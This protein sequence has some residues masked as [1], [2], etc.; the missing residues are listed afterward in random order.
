M[1]QIKRCAD[2]FTRQATKAQ[3]NHLYA[4]L[5][6]RSRLPLCCM[7][8]SGLRFNCVEFALQKDV[9][10]AT[11]AWAC[12]GEI[13][14]VELFELDVQTMAVWLAALK[15]R[16]CPRRATEIVSRLVLL[17]EKGCRVED[18]VHDSEGVKSIFWIM[19]EISYRCRNDVAR[20]V[21]ME[22]IVR[23]QVQAMD[24]LTSASMRPS[25]TYFLTGHGLPDHLGD[26]PDHE[27]SGWTTALHESVKIASYRMVE[28]LVL[29]EFQVNAFDAKG[30]TAYQYSGARLTQAGHEPRI[31]G[32]ESYEV[33]R[34]AALLSQSTD[35]AW[36]PQV[37]HESQ[38]NVELSLP[39]G[40]DR[41]NST[42]EQGNRKIRTSVTSKVPST[43]TL[44]LDRH[45][46]SITLKSPTFSFFTDQRLALGFRKVHL[47]G[48][49]YY[50]DLLRFLQPPSSLSSRSR[51]SEPTYSL[52]Y[53]EREA[54]DSDT[55]RTLNVKQSV[56][57]LYFRLQLVLAVAYAAI[58]SVAWSIRSVVLAVRRALTYLARCF[59]LVTER[60]IRYL[61][62]PLSIL[63]IFVLALVVPGQPINIYLGSVPAAFVARRF[64]WSFGMKLLVNLVAL[65]SL[66]N[67]G[68]TALVVFVGLDRSDPIFVDMVKMFINF[69]VVPFGNIHVEISVSKPS[70]F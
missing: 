35:S 57:V 66:S 2:D 7:R 13:G 58:A 14:K 68:Q 8:K 23:L 17:V 42:D 29:N 18:A 40:W 16:A 44:Y 9:S 26:L 5:R 1:E 27:T 25:L 51:I 46:G 19:L 64:A 3:T 45:F 31:D 4:L 67:L 53:Y 49:T 39:I 37:R 60:T 11:L 50:L 22:C 10:F 70:I 62:L 34:I 6:V 55:R 59:C 33:D 21:F 30:K 32:T 24:T 54:S 47:P 65:A 69:I 36:S 63:S 61:S 52:A 48:Q 38:S 15:I 43:V 41:I 56:Q 12:H 20:D 28:A